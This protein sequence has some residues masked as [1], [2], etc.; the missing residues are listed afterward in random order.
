MSCISNVLLWQYN[1]AYTEFFCKYSD[2]IQIIPL[3]DITI[4][5][6]IKNQATRKPTVPTSLLT[7]LVLPPPLVMVCVEQCIQ[8]LLWPVLFSVWDSDFLIQGT[9]FAESFFVHVS[10]YIYPGRGSDFKE[11]TV[12]LSICTC[13]MDS[14]LNICNKLNVDYMK[15]LLHIWRLKVIENNSCCH[16]MQR[17]CYYYFQV[18]AFLYQ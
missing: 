11:D 16:F 2:V 7:Q 12:D 13:L 15:L 1:R 14:A 10:A 8:I 4:C 9:C 18:N 6:T 5:Y 17:M 3:I